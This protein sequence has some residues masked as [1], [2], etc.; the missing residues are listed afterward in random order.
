MEN[1][2]EKETTLVCKCYRGDL[3]YEIVTKLRNEFREIMSELTGVNDQ[4][5]GTPGFSIPL[6]TSSKIL[7]YQRRSSERISSEKIVLKVVSSQGGNSTMEME[8]QYRTV[9]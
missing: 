8:H 9:L 7:V 4:N 2:K 5:E 1:G 6:T 3:T